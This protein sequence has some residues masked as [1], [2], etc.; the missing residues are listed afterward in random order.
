MAESYSVK[1]ILSAQDK[2]FSSIMKSCQ[3]YASNLKST[4]MGGLGFGAMAAIGGKA[5]SLVTNS[6]SDLSKET[7][8]TSDS[9]YKLQA[10]MR[11]SGYAEDEIQR[12]AGATGSLKTYV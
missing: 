12:I 1:A 8:E 2:N 10:A 6:V 9:M 11:F 7:I 5:V 4:L 3:G